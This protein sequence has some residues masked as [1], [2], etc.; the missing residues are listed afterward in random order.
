VQKVYIGIIFAL[1]ILCAMLGRRS[2]YEGS[3]FDQIIRDYKQIRD[4]QQSIIAGLDNLSAKLGAVS[5]QIKGI[6]KG[7][8]QVNTGLGDI[9]ERLGNAQGTVAESQQL[10]EEQRRILEG[11]KKGGK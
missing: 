10:I 11:V 1:L 6:S 2:Y 5:N 4:A 8:G 3:R 7:I 9:K